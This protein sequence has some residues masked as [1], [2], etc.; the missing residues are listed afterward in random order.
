MSDFVK[1][2]E[3]LIGEFDND[4]KE[5]SAFDA[6]VDE[7]LV[8]I[9]DFMQNNHVVF[10]YG[11][12]KCLPC[13]QVHQVLEDKRIEKALKACEVTAVHV[14]LSN[15]RNEAI[16]EILDGRPRSV[17][18]YSAFDNNAKTQGTLFQHKQLDV[19]SFLFFL[20]SWYSCE[21]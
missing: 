11:A 4:F 14:N 21:N 15:Y 13:V 12:D 17:P 20:K 10:V 8:K 19:N 1:P 18:A 9:V 5:R 16:M 3:E 7:D 2:I 6:R